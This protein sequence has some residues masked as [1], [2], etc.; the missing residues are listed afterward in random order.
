MSFQSF[1]N[2]S[3]G[4]WVGYGLV[5]IGFIL[6]GCL[7]YFNGKH[8]W[9]LGREWDERTALAVLHAAVD[10][11]TALLVSAAAIFIA[12][13]HPWIGVNICL[14][15]LLLTSYS[16]LTTAGFMSNRL[17][18]AFSQ[19]AQMA[20]LEKQGKWWGSASYKRELTRGE[21]LANRAEM[22]ATFKEAMKVTTEVHDPQALSLAGMTGL[23]V[24]TVQRWL[25]LISSGIGQIMKYACLLV[26]FSLLSNRDRGTQTQSNS[27]TQANSAGNSGGSGG[28]DPKSRLKVV[29]N[30]PKSPP[31]EYAS[32]EAASG[33]SSAGG[34]LKANG[35][36]VIELKASSP[37]A[38]GL[39]S[40]MSSAR[41]DAPRR[42]QY[43]AEQLHAYLSDV[44]A[45]DI[46]VTTRVMAKETGWSQSKV[47]KSVKKLRGQLRVPYHKLRYGGYGGGDRVSASYQ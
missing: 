29:T 16:M 5:V 44:I 2:S 25:N 9:S 8:G 24:D 26:G 15:A 45:R 34:A 10:P 31:A 38:L 18:G 3:R 19:K 28:S 42:G 4:L 17:V 13:R 6:T 23:A 39:S 47:A 11:V 7:M 32:P 36:T 30:S 37:A 22:R 46:K 40:Q 1:K 33:N 41:S 20:E 35:A 14:F 21:R 43:T 27:G 12:W